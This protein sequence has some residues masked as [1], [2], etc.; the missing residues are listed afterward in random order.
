M[1]LSSSAEMLVDFPETSDELSLNSP[2]EIYVPIKLSYLQC[3]PKIN[4][5][6]N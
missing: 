1:Y 5:N 6:L 4:V 2:S 3:N